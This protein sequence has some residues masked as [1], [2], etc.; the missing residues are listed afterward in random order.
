MHMKAIRQP[1]RQRPTHY[2]PV[3]ARAICAAQVC[4]HK[5]AVAALGVPPPH[6]LQAG[7]AARHGGHI[8]H[9][10]AITAS[11]REAGAAGEGREG[12]AKRKHAGCIA[13]Q[14]C[15]NWLSQMPKWLIAKVTHRSSTAP[16]THGPCPG[17]RST[18]ER[19]LASP[20][21]SATGAVGRGAPA[22][23][24]SRWRLLGTGTSCQVASAGGGPC[25]DTSL[26]MPCIVREARHTAVALR[27][28][29]SSTPS[30]AGASSAVADVAV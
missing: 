22:A 27:R 18:W 3:N 25:W 6:H 14:F 21:P 19:P 13:K 20:P 15:A 16:M 4:D 2:P 17:T 12:A 26:M 24:T 29:A 9:K 11:R 30:T 8:K 5:L 1:A 7:V 23:S 10:V 28:L